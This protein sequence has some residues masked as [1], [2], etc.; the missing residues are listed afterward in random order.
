MRWDD[1]LTLQ[2][3]VDHGWRVE[4]I[5]ATHHEIKGCL[6][7]AGGYFSWCVPKEDGGSDFVAVHDLHTIGDAIALLRLFGIEAHG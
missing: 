2:W 5:A 3:L 6:V 1:D 4:G 7:I